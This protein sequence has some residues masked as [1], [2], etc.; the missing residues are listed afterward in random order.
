MKSPTLIHEE[1]KTITDKE[2]KQLINEIEQEL[3]NRKRIEFIQLRDNIIK[4]IKEM[5][6]RFPLAKGLV[7]EDLDI[8]ILGYDIDLIVFSID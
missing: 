5:Q 1:L 7:S 2:L 8:D 6:D 4:A 3:K